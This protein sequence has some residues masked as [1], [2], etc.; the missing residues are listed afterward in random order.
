MSAAVILRM[1]GKQKATLYSHLFPADGFEAVAVALCGRRVGTEKHCLSVS[2]LVLIPHHECDRRPDGIQW[3][4]D[5][6]VPLLEEAGR[7]GMAVAKIHSHPGGYDRFSAFDDAS[8]REFFQAAESWTE[9]SLPHGSIVALPCGRMFGRTQGNGQEYLPMEMIAVAGDSIEYWFD[10]PTDPVPQF[11]DRHAQVLGESTV[12]T[13]R[14]LRAAVVGC[15][16]TGSPTVEQLYRLGVGELVL[17][18]PD[19][20]GVENL[21]RIVNAGALDAQ[22]RRTKVQLLQKA[23][24]HAGLG[25]DVIALAEDLFTQD[26]VREV[27]LCDVIFGC[28]DS[29]F[30]RHVLNKLSS[31]YCI[32]Y[33]DL[34]VGLQADGNGGIAHISGAVHYLQPD[35]SSLLS[36]GV[37]TLDA[38]QADALRR[39][40]PTEHS[41]RLAAGYIAGANVARPAVIS[42]NMIFSGLGVLEFLHRIHPMRDEPN[43]Q[44]AL[45]RLSLSNGLKDVQD[46]GE[47][48]LV[49][50]RTLGRGDMRPLLGMPELSSQGEQVHEHVA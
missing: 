18:D 33:F 15:S 17:V 44:F 31:T 45:Q 27:A 2:R 38:V 30:A 41:K 20:V 16:G 34:G 35:G 9:C 24:H 6:L 3:S 37:Y 5:K 12:M 28:V 13:L 40:D 50:S 42:V 36:R 11:T 29:V 4:T 46:D 23:I 49:V 48:C 25:T 22:Q 39:T 1:T 14:R 47:R 7:Q 10:Q 26:V 19:V 21:N 8:D 43:G 32:P